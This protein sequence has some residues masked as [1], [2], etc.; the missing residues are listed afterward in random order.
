MSPLG[1]AGIALFVYSLYRVMLR[2]YGR[3]VYPLVGLAVF[4]LFARA[5]DWDKKIE[6][7]PH[8]GVSHTIWLAL[9][10]GLLAAYG[11][12]LIQRNG[13]RFEPVLFG[14]GALAVLAHLAGDIITPMGLTPLAPLSGFHHTFELVYAR[15]TTV[16]SAFL[17][18]GVISFC[19]VT[20]L[21]D[22]DR[23]THMFR[24]LKN[25]L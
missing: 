7:I 15:N 4:L 23:W 25:R 16:N 3:D 22:R 10:A 18:A 8:R 21:Y 6:M 14:Y 13:F 1:H 11:I 19:T 2:R 9:L 17:V 24:S 12:S 5:P 20:Y